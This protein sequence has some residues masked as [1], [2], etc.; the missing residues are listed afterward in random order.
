MRPLLREDISYFGFSCLGAYLSRKV[1]I[2]ALTK[3]LMPDTYFEGE[4]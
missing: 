1:M 4:Q 3:R 2:V